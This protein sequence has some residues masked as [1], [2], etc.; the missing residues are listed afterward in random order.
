MKQARRGYEPPR[1]R[2]YEPP[3][4]GSAPL[5]EG[6]EKEATALE[7]L[8]ELNEQISAAIE[9]VKTLKEE[10]AELERKIKRLEG[11][12]ETK[13]IEIQALG[14]EKSAIKGQIEDLL[15]EIETVYPG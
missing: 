12:M 8:K 9:K 5:F 15:S 7:K 13:D 10:K 2:G 3:R 6:R 14:T 4:K 1:N 11:L